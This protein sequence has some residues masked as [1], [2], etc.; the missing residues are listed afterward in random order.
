VR[1]DPLDRDAPVE[2]LEAHLLGQEDLGHT[3][4]G[5]PP[6]QHVVAEPN[7]C[8]GWHA[9]AS[10]LYGLAVCDARPRCAS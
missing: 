10:Y 2:P 7:A 8:F 5:N 4:A 1:E 3:A 6:Q 9:R